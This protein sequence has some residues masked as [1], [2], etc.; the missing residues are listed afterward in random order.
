MSRLRFKYTNITAQFYIVQFH[1]IVLSESYYRNVVDEVASQAAVLGSMMPSRNLV[2]FATSMRCIAAA[3]IC[4]FFC[5]I[6][7]RAGFQWLLRLANW[8]TGHKVVEFGDR[9]NHFVATTLNSFPQDLMS[10]RSDDDRVTEAQK[11][12]WRRICLKSSDIET[13]NGT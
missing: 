11:R 9:R 12:F 7:V 3:R 6:L 10:R 4:Q 2:S 5:A 13:C 1:R 8:D